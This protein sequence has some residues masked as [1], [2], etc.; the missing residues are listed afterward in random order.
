MTSLPPALR[1]WAQHLSLFPEDLALAVGAHA[2]RLAAAIGPLRPRSEELGGEPMGYDG[3]TRRGTPE[4]LLLSEW[5]LALEE[6]DEFLRRAAWG[7]QSFLRTAFRQPRGGRRTVVLLDTGP[8]QL[9]APRV[10]HLAL[11]VVLTRRAES[12][13]AALAW[14]PLQASP[15]QGPFIALTSA[16]VQAWLRSASAQPPTSA[17]LAAWREALQLGPS[18][19]E[20]WLVGGARL[21][22]LPE[23]AGLSRVQ[24]MEAPEPGVRQLQVQV[25][26]A[27]RPE[28]QV[29][30]ELPAP[31]DCVRLLRDPFQTATT[32]TLVD[33]PRGVRSLRLSADGL[34][35]LLVRADGSLAT[36]AIPQSPRATVP[37]ARRFHPLPNESLVAVGWRRTGGLLAVT[38]RP[39]GLLVHGLIKEGSPHARPTLFTHQALQP[40]PQL[41]SAGSPLLATSRRYPQVETVLLWDSEGVLHPLDVSARGDCSVGQ[42]LPGVLALAESG[43]R[44]CLLTRARGGEVLLGSWGQ[45]GLRFM[46]LGLE[47]GERALFGD[48]RSAGPLEPGVLAVCRQPGS[49]CLVRYH[50]RMELQVPMDLRVV[51][52]L[53]HAEGAELLALSEDRRS[54]LV[55]GPQR[56]RVL[57]RTPVAVVHAEA[58]HSLPVVAWLTT[59]GEVAVWSLQH[60]AFVFRS[61]PGVSP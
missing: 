25:R 40:A 2:A 8:E 4:R 28:R 11:L 53:N 12:A 33:S 38:S 20:A 36:Q 61:A 47:Y 7:E 15:E 43:Q 23:A 45:E 34:R 5:G 32:A 50:A 1:P 41:G 3:L 44:T 19:E 27:G 16:T 6:P 55:V 31:A 29:R 14:A 35:L 51:G 17:Q 52:V 59:S 13:G 60:Q 39:E 22:R 26:P 54:L 30:L 21:G 24:V 48:L 46:P 37:R 18:A 10:A 56:T 9:G 49:W 58:S 42:P 57:A